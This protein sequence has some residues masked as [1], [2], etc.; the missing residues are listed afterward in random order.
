MKEAWTGSK[1]EKRSAPRFNLYLPL[2]LRETD[3][4]DGQWERGFSINVSRLGVCI[5][6]RRAL[7]IQKKVEM[8]L[9]P[10]PGGK[11]PADRGLLLSGRVVRVE[12]IHGPNWS[13]DEGFAVGVMFDEE[14]DLDLLAGILAPYRTPKAAGV[15]A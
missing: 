4:T 10:R 9:I 13:G 2:L 5:L 14:F 11:D 6:A 12:R 7:A 8:H 15:G 1:N 3:G